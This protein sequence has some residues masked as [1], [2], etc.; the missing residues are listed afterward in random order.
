MEVTARDKMDQEE[1]RPHVR[2]VCEELVF[3]SDFDSGNLA[4][5][6]KVA[7]SSVC[8]MQFE[9][10]V[11]PDAA[12]R[13]IT[14]YRSWFYFGIRGA[15]KGSHIKLSIVNLSPNK[16]LFGNRYKPVYQLRPGPPLWNLFS[17]E[18]TYETTS[19][20]QAKL[21]WIFELDGGELEVYFACAFPYPYQQIR[22]SVT[23]H[24]KAATS[25][26]YFYREVLA[27]SLEGR[28]VEI[29]TISDTS[30]LSSLRESRPVGLFPTDL[31]RCH[32]PLKPVI[33]VTARVHP[34]ETPGS[35]M[36][37]GFL[38]A[39]LAQDRRGLLLRKNFVFKVVPVLN[40]D[41]VYHGNF[42]LDV[43]GVNLNRCYADPDR[44]SFPVIYA[45]KTYLN[46][47]NT[48]GA[49]AF[50]MDFHAQSSKPSSFL[51]GNA[52]VEEQ[53]VDNEL[54]AKLISLESHTF[55]FVY[56]DFSE[57][58]M[59]S[60]DPKDHHSKEGSGRVAVHRSTGVVHCYTVECSYTAGRTAVVP[61]VIRKPTNQGNSNWSA[62]FDLG[63]SCA[64]ALLS[65]YDLL[66]LPKGGDFPNL[67]AVRSHI[68]TS[69][70]L[71]R[72]K[73]RLPR[74]GSTHLDSKADLRKDALK[75]AL[76]RTTPRAVHHLKV[77][78][79]MLNI[80]PHLP[81]LERSKD[82]TKTRRVLSVEGKIRRRPW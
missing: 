73:A 48:L 68:R 61:A 78:T 8:D 35:Y 40:P 20:Q 56:C 14:A 59:Y 2:V 82:R 77:V 43:N 25:D 62:Y 21:T 12:D 27:R 7:P 58:S 31:G 46:Y 70:Q 5:A 80:E 16:T 44:A 52:L 4:K 54:Y 29:L 75:P 63:V 30:N 47:L 74:K 64:G 3:F 42:R 28:D 57:R 6:V 69:L 36:L 37:D 41:G 18:V 26:T 34:G 79:P 38:A 67:E 23:I 1:I 65:Y 22:D 51:F 33:V 72:I 71:D 39:V 32:L 81:P 50:Y 15:R 76:G 55:S 24:E 10:W 9:L 45:V 60:K 11:C 53:Q 13:G 49:L 66:Q 19:E 17:G